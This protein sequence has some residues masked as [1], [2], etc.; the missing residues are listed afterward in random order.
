MRPFKLLLVDDHALLREALALN[1]EK[2]PCVWAAAA[3]LA[4]LGEPSRSTRPRE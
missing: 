4:L 2:L 1:L 3:S